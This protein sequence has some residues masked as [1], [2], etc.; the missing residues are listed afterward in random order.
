MPVR[1]TS[2]RWGFLVLLAS[3]TVGEA[4]TMELRQSLFGRNFLLP[5]TA[6]K[7]HTIAPPT[8]RM[9]A[10]ARPFF[11]TSPSD[12]VADPTQQQKHYQLVHV[13]GRVLPQ[14]VSVAVPKPG[15]SQG[16]LKASNFASGL[17]VLDCTILPVVT[18]ILPLFGIVAGSPAQMEWLHQLGH[19]LA[20]WF[21]LPVGGLATSLNYLLQHRKLWI[22][23]TGWTGLALVLAANFG[24]GGCGA[25]AA[26]HGGAVVTAAPA[27]LIHWL[28]LVNHGVLHRV[29][30]L[31]GCF[32]LLGSN[33]LSHKLGG[34]AHGSS[35]KHDH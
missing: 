30:N 34:C 20:L 32:L 11:S 33:Y 17:C 14:A 9:K 19:S 16:L 5:R 3:T 35:C 26:H 15:F 4:F 22:A 10:A 23:A 28:H 6:E 2:C 21:V 12:A 7:Q 31:A 13:G 24:G 25:A 27:F 1:L 8:A 29:T 18:V